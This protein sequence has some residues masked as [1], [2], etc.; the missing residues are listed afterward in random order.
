MAYDK[1]PENPIVYTHKE[2]GA[3]Y[4]DRS[5]PNAYERMFMICRSINYDFDNYNKNYSTPDVATKRRYWRN[6]FRFLDHPMRYFFWKSKPYF[7]SGKIR[8]FPM[9]WFVLYIGT[10]WQAGGHLASA[11]HQVANENVYSGKAQFEFTNETFTYDR[12]QAM[13]FH[14]SEGNASKGL[15][16]NLSVPPSSVFCRLNYH[17]RDQNYRKY[18]AHRERRG[19]DLF[20]GK[21]LNN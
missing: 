10:W 2:F 16:S 1:A 12:T 3:A 7:L 11:A 4:F 18:F 21:P 5:L 13:H 19:A 14:H 8:F 15:M 20:T 9:Y 17:V 6:F